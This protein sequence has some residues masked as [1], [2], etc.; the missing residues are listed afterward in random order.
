MLNA[1]QACNRFLQG[2]F[3]YCYPKL[4]Q[5]ALSYTTLQAWFGAIVA[6]I[7]GWRGLLGRLTAHR[8]GRSIGPADWAV[9]GYRSRR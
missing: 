1:V 3:I 7:L 2:F 5:V 4:W 8:T 6:S 9:S